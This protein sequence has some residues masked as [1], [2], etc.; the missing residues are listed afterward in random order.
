MLSS[1]LEKSRS[2]AG[3]ALGSVPVASSSDTIN[4]KPRRRLCAPN[5]R[6][7]ETSS[8]VYFGLDGDSLW[9]T[10]RLPLQ[11]ETW[12]NYVSRSIPLQ[13]ERRIRIASKVMDS[14]EG[15]RHAIER[16][17]S[18]SSRDA[19]RRQEIVAKFYEDDR[20]ISC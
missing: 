7:R 12:E 15:H 3:D 20:G 17:E 16:G 18:R 14:A 1:V 19:R 2:A 6:L 10:I 9:T 4:P 8:A 11:E 5:D 13:G